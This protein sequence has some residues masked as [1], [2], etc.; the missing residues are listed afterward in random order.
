MLNAIV[1]VCILILDQSLKY[2]TILNLVPGEGSKTLIPGVVELVNVHNTGAAFGFLE[3]GRWFFV[4]LT[5]VV[6]IDRK[7]TRLN[8]SHL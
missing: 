3:D 5:L 4:G 6:A 8:S 1:A 7:S 2:W